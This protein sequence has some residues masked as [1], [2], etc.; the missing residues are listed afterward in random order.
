MGNVRTNATPM[1]RP[2]GSRILRLMEKRSE[3]GR[4]RMQIPLRKHNSNRPSA[5][6]L[7]IRERHM[8]TSLAWAWKLAG[9]APPMRSAHTVCRLGRG[10][11]CRVAL[12]AESEERRALSRSLGFS[13]FC[14]AALLISVSMALG[15]SRCVPQCGAG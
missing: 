14:E 9:A 15:H 4:G 8:C 11:R 7:R 2:P 13:F 5:P 1:R 3:K 12:A 10:G 6:R